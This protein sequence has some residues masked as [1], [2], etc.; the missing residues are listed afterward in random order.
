MSVALYMDVH[1]PLP[2]TSALPARRRMDSIRRHWEWQRRA[3]KEELFDEVC[4]TS[5]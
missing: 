5:E 2:I 4:Q 1:V 3:N